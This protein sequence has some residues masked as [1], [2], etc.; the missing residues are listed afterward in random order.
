MK[1]Q[2][3]SSQ[4]LEGVTPGN[5]RP[6]ASGLSATAVEKS[7]VSSPSGGA[8]TSDEPGFRAI[9]AKLAAAWPLPHPVHSGL[10]AMLDALR[11]KDTEAVPPGN[12]TRGETQAT[13]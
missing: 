7:A 4:Q 1:P 10:T 11:R 3:A 9:V 2:G 12:A 5:T 13:S 6:L 8:A